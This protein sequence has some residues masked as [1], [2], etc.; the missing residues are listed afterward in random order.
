VTRQPA[1]RCP[2]LLTVAG[3][4]TQGMLGQ[5]EGRTADDAAYW[6]VGATSAWHDAIQ[7]AA[8]GM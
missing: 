1:G 3:R 7:A 4:G 2:G 6:L 5:A 8:I